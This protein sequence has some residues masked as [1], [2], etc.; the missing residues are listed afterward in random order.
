MPTVP[1]PLVNHL[2]APGQWPAGSTALRHLG[3]L[4]ETACR[5]WARETWGQIVITP[6]EQA[7]YEPDAFLWRNVA[8]RAVLVFTPQVVLSDPPAFWA[9]VGA[10]LDHWLGAAAEPNRPWLSE[11]GSPTRPKA[12]VAAAADLQTI[13]GRGYAAAAFEEA[14]PRALF[15]RAFAL[16]MTDSKTLFAAD[17]HLARWFR[18]TLLEEAWWRQWAA[19]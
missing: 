18:R 10:W 1:S 6:L 13:L 16:A 2:H 11:G 4:P 5:R 15:T 3:R 17:P 14:D 19:T 9:I 7:R 12:I 8:S